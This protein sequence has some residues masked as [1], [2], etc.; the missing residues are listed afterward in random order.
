MSGR[1]PAQHCDG[2]LGPRKLQCNK[3]TKPSDQNSKKP[4]WALTQLLTYVTLYHQRFFKGE[5]YYGKTVF[6]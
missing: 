1:E 2:A 5:R 6:I 4:I 3:S